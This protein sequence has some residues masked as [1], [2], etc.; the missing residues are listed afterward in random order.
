MLQGSE[1]LPV[2]L[3]DAMEKVSPVH[4]PSGVVRIQNPVGTLAGSFVYGSE[5]QEVS[6]P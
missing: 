6:V 5:D 3:S 1:C 2:V 4:M